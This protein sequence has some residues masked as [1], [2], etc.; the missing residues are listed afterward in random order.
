MLKS[1]HFRDNSRLAKAL[2]NSP[3]MKKGETGH[4]LRLIQRALYYAID[5][6]TEGQHHNV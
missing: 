2:M 3:P 1:G 4:A 5:L 6:A